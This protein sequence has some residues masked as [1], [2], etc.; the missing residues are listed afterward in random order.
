ALSLPIYVVLNGWLGPMGLAL[1]TSVGITLNLTLTLAAYQWLAT[2]RWEASS[3]GALGLASL[4]GGFTRG[5]A[6]GVA[7]AAA[8]WGAQVLLAPQVSVQTFAGALVSLCVVGA[9]FGAGAG[10][11]AAAIRPEEL[12]HVLGYLRRKWTGKKR[13][14]RTSS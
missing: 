7:G 4:A 1:S 3:A 9:A 5:V 11:L 8:G 14:E 10:V 2:R 13:E 12:T 6:L